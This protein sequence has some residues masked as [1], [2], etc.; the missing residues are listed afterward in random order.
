MIEP[1]GIAASII[2][3]GALSKGIVLVIKKTYRAAKA[4]PNLT[5]EIKRAPILLLTSGSAIKTCYRG[6]QSLE[7]REDDAISILKR[8][9]NDKKTDILGRSHKYAFRTTSSSFGRNQIPSE[10]L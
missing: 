6:L 9:R 8:L 2:T 7:L 3:I 5:G 10:P 1:I 4:A